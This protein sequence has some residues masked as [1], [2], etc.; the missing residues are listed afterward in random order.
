MC[1]LAKVESE[2]ANVAKSIR[3]GNDPCRNR[4]RTDGNGRKSKK[5]FRDRTSSPSSPT[6]IAKPRKKPK[7]KIVNTSSKIKSKK[8]KTRN[9]VKVGKKSTKIRDADNVAVTGH[10]DTKSA[11]SPV[12]SSKRRI[13]VD[14]SRR[15]EP[16]SSAPKRRIV[17]DTL[18]SVQLPDSPKLTAV[19][20][21]P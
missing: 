7:S 3:G 15:E 17:V 2:I 10:T 6:P 1:E 18:H 5:K 11:T 8:N 12:T 20:S 21:M 9:S 16:T 13:Y 14:P 4:Q 19:Y